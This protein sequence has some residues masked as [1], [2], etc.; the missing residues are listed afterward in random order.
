MLTAGHRVI[1]EE[2]FDA[3]ES[4]TLPWARHACERPLRGI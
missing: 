1:V 4:R 3:G 2:F